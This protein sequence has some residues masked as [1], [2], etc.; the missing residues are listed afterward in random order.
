MEEFIKKPLVPNVPISGDELSD[1]FSISPP[2]ETTERCNTHRKKNDILCLQ[3]KIKVC[4]N[5][6]LFGGHKIH[7]VIPVDE[8]V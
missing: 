2:P 4:S 3:C 1:R 8:A 7:D 5:C 6:A